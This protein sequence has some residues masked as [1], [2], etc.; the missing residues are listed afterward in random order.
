MMF[1]LNST[2]VW[3]EANEQ[4]SAAK[5]WVKEQLAHKKKNEQHLWTN[6]DQYENRFAI[7]RILS[8]SDKLHLQLVSC[9][10]CED[11]SQNP[12]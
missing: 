4:S 10:E 2:I 9:D 11:S 5:Q 1:I 3:Q 12:C 8:I 7:I 6:P